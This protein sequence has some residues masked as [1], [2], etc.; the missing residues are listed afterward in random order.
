MSRALWYYA[1][2]VDQDIIPSDAAEPTMQEGVDLLAGP[3][4]SQRQAKE[5]RNRVYTLIGQ[6]YPA[7]LFAE[8]QYPAGCRIVLV[9][10]TVSR[11][12][13]Y[14]ARHKREAGVEGVYWPP[15]LCW[16]MLRDPAM[17]GPKPKE[18][19]LV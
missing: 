19:V 10:V 8:Y 16:R 9:P 6:R 11:V 3:Y 12:A 2:I 13:R 14:N 4:Q 7:C 18:L 15:S 17:S 1:F 5:N